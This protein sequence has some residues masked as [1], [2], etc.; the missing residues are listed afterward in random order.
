[1]DIHQLTEAQIKEII[2]HLQP[3]QLKA[4]E[5]MQFDKITLQKELEEADFNN[6]SLSK[7]MQYLTQKLKEAENMHQAYQ[8]QITHYQKE[9]ATLHLQLAI[10]EKKEAEHLKT[11]EAL[12]ATKGRYN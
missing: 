1:M 5:Q 10:A 6:A 4:F 3:Q 12:E 11:I 9:M 2:S 7:S 8:Q